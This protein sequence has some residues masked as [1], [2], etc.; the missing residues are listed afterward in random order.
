MFLPKGSYRQ[1]FQIQGLL[2]DFIKIIH[3][4]KDYNFMKNTNLHYKILLLKI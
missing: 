3:V 2:K 1:V 4:F